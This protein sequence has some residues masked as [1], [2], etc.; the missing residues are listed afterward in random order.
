MNVV[1]IPFYGVDMKLA[2]A[3]DQKL[4]QLTR[5]LDDQR[6]V[7]FVHFVQHSAQFLIIG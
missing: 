7:G 4:F 5:K 2:L 1:K 6:G 3:L